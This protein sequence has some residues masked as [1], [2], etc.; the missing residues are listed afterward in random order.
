MVAESLDQLLS[1]HDLDAERSVLEAVM[2]EPGRLTK[3]TAILTPADFFRAAHGD[4]FA[5]MI[6]VAGTRALE[7]GERAGPGLEADPA[8]RLGSVGG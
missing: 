6:A 4:I 2:V 1:P 3:A 7:R 8:W 5:A